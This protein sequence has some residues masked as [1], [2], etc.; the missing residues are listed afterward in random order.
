M[1]L[2][3][4]FLCQLAGILIVMF[5]Q[6]NAILA[7]TTTDYTAALSHALTTCTSRTDLLNK[8]A[9]IHRSAY[10]KG[11]DV[12][13]PQNLT[14]N[15][16]IPQNFQPIKLTTNTDFNGCTFVVENKQEKTFLFELSAKNS[17]KAVRLKKKLLK[18]GAIIKLGKT[19]PKLLTVKD[20]NLWT[21]RYDFGSQG[22]IAGVKGKYYRKDIFFI[23]DSIVMNNPIVTYDNNASNP[24]Y[25]YVDVTI[26]E[27]AFR[28]ISLIR[29]VS[30]SAITNLLHIE[31]Q[32]NVRIENVDIKTELQPD[33]K[34]RFYNDQCIKI[35]N[36][37]KIKMANVTVLNTYSSQTIWGYAIEMNNVWDSSFSNL[38][39]TAIRGG[40]NTTCA[41][42][43]L[44][45]DCILNRVDVHYYGRDI[46]CKNCTF[47]NTVNNFH[48][49]NR[50]ASFYGTLRYENC[51]FDHFLPVRIDSEYNA[52][53]PFNV[54]MDNCTLSII[55]QTPSFYNC[56]CYV[57]IL[58]SLENDRP[59]L[60]EKCL[61][62]LNINKLIIVGPKM[63][64]DFYFFII[65]RPKY[66]GNIYGL[67]NINVDNVVYAID[68]N[69]PLSFHDSNHQLTMSTNY[70][71]SVSHIKR[72]KRIL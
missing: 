6:S 27:K 69:T 35:D 33:V 15:I 65:N 37:A 22:E 52:F 44:F 72:K 23:A 25:K 51:F 11:D 14:F 67:Q 21:T 46:I 38:N 57:P 17:P 55:Y 42:T 19:G 43:M 48:V 68:G 29:K 2:E 16:A 18:A 31:H 39:I 71:R 50:V 5:F 58:E 63:V 66:N 56:I 62:N 13:Y 8:I 54:E 41:N 40:F 28:N 64:K 10:E 9:A 32:Y 4:T 53:T 1:N 26:D 59:E 20:E 7:T 34:D 36:S 45:T 24:S 60:K 3:K 61:P 49:Y 47:R 30:S 70:K 12:V